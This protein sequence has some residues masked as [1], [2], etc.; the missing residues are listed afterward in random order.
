ML[1]IYGA[2]AVTD[3]RFKRTA[4][5]VFQIILRNRQRHLRRP[6]LGSMAVFVCGRPR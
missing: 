1:M 2:A 5:W 3:E 4:A 6:S